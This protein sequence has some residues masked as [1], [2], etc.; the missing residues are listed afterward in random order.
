MKTEPND[1]ELVAIVAAYTI[2]VRDG[3]SLAP[4]PE[5]APAWRRAARL[6][7]VGDAEAAARDTKHRGRWRASTR[8]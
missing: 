6:E 5:P 3:R 1:D 8:P 4:V 2:L 7:G